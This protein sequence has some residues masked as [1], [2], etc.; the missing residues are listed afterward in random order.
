MGRDLAKHAKT[1]WRQLVSFAMLRSTRGPEFTQ[2][3]RALKSLED[4]FPLTLA[5]KFQ[6]L[7]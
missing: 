2:R 4:E 1:R 7:C 6:G 3:F 5:Q